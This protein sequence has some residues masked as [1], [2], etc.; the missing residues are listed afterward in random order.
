VLP[1]GK[2]PLLIAVAL[3]GFGGLVVRD[4][5]LPVLRLATA[6]AGAPA[7][8]EPPAEGVSVAGR[9]LITERAP[10]TAGDPS[11]RSRSPL[12]TGEAAW[13]AIEQQQREAGLG[14]LQQPAFDDRLPTAL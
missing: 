3:L 14:K 8:V 7:Q 5:V 11:R 13:R 2:L 1:S 12:L 9:A 10:R 6:Q 4:H